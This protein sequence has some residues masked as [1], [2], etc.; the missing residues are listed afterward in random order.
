MQYDV[1]FSSQY[2]DL[3]HHEWR[4]RGCGIASLHMVLKFCGR[5]VPLDDLL[6]EGLAVGAYREGIGWTHRG[7]VE[8]A[9]RH[10]CHAYNIDVAPNSTTP[11]LAD[12]AWG[13]LTTELE[14]GPVLASVHSRFDPTVP[15]GHIVVVTGWDGEL[16]AL[17]DPVELTEREGHKLLAAAVFRRAFKQR[18]I[19]VRPVE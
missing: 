9:R 8:L 3:G 18:Y 10:G 13:M 11:K 7:L 6:Q 17:N 19:A 4:A 14:W 1:P 5:P 12:A 15:D 2:A 16:V